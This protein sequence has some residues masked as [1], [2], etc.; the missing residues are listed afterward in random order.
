[1]DMLIYFPDID[2]VSERVISSLYV[3]SYL[4]CNLYCMYMY[5]VLYVHVY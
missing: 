5:I 3:L 2:R 4:L 1:M